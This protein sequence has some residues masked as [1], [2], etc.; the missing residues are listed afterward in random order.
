MAKS[1][2]LFDDEGNPIPTAT[3]P[4]V[5][6]DRVTKTTRGFVN[7]DK[8]FYGLPIRPEGHPLVPDKSIISRYLMD[9]SSTHLAD[10]FK[11]FALGMPLFLIGETGC[12]KTEAIKY[13]CAKA[14]VPL[15]QIQGHAHLEWEDLIGR[16]VPSEK[17]G[18][19][20]SYEDG[21][22]TLAIQ[23]EGCFLL[24][25]CASVKQGILN[26]LNELANGGDLVISNEKGIRTVKRTPGFRMCMTANPWDN[27]AGNNELNIAFLDRFKM[28]EFDYMS[29]AAEIGLLQKKYPE[30][31]SGTIQAMVGVANKS[32]MLKKKKPDSTR[33]II[34]T[35]TLQ[36]ICDEIVFLE[37][38][39]YEAFEDCVLSIVRL[40]AMD[41]YE[42]LKG[43]IENIITK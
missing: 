3:K 21:P 26:G 28:R 30:I 16:Y 43:T 23:N 2:Q 13:A 15:Y 8:N 5:D 6:R 31:S 38:S 18:T 9:T 37:R 27:Y 35:R 22:L 42:A 17:S 41:E 36:N 25:E 34:S 10:T 11:L 39:P 32:R 4:V 14:N 20:F 19:G 12:G 33:Y 40:T 7:D 29:K 24:D 1:A